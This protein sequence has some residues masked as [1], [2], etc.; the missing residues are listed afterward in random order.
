MSC[1]GC[2]VDD[3]VSF[4]VKSMGLLFY[5]YSSNTGFLS[6]LFYANSDAPGISHCAALND[7]RLKIFRGVES[8]SHQWSQFIRDSLAQLNNI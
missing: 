3:I 5:T 1:S 7:Q 2:T 8:Q 6:D 4:K